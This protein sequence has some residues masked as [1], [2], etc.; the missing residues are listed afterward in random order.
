MYAGGSWPDPSIELVA[1][2]SSNARMPGFGEW[3]ATV[4]EHT[5]DYVD[6]LSLH[7]YLV[8]VHKVGYFADRPCIFSPKGC[9]NAFFKEVCP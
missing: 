6:Y 2:G 5:C 3:E 1:C 7:I 9:E 4:L 8:S